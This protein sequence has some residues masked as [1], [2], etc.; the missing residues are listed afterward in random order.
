MPGRKPIPSKNRAV[1]ATPWPAEPAKKL[2]RAVTRHQYADNNP[3]RSNPALS[4]CE[5]RFSTLPT[6]PPRAN[7]GRLPSLIA[8]SRAGMD[9]FVV[10]AAEPL[11]EEVPPPRLDVTAQVEYLCSLPD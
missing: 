6:S 3:N 5:S 10:W 11:V 1:P 7:G 4:R 9:W 2:L 8:K